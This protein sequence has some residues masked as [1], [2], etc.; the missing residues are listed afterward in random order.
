M[1]LPPFP[2][3]AHTLDLLMAAI[4]P[5]GVGGNPDARRSC[6]SDFLA[7][8][9]EMGG[10]DIHAVAEVHDDGSDG[11]PV[12][13]TMRDPQYTDHCV[14]TALVDEVRRLRTLVAMTQT[15]R[16]AACAL[17]GYPTHG[18]FCVAVP[19]EPDA[20]MHT[21]AC[22]PVLNED[23]RLIEPTH[24]RDPDGTVRRIE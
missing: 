12:V 20:V 18:D 21:V 1:N 17:C 5:W 7:L 14:I 24:V 2:V 6:L 11:G 4:D 19:G 3:D 10:S 13:V 15:G 23:T 22:G 9:S 16:P 8:M